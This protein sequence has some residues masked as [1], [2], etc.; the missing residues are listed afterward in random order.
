MGLVIP[1]YTDAGVIAIN[2]HFFQIVD[3]RAPEE[4]AEDDDIPIAEAISILRFMFQMLN[5][6][7]DDAVVPGVAVRDLVESNFPRLHQFLVS[8]EYGVPP[9]RDSRLD[10]GKFCQNFRQL[11]VSYLFPFQGNTIYIL[12]FDFQHF[13]FY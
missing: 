12:D 3:S 2:D 5:L 11:V 7:V 4:E 1:F 10:Y 8:P 13:D 9:P 6:G